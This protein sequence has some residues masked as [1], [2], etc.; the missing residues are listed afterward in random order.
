MSKMP[1]VQSVM[2]SVTPTRKSTRAHTE[3]QML[4]LKINTHSCKRLLIRDACLGSKCSIRMERDALRGCR[5]AT[6]VDQKEARLG[7]CCGWATVSASA[8]FPIGG[9]VPLE[10]LTFFC[11]TLSDEDDAS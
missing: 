10:S 6:K 5:E 3:K 4:A 9:D 2:T 7:V 11:P 8:A 1:S